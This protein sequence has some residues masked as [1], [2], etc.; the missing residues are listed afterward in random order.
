MFFL[1]SGPS[2]FCRGTRDRDFDVIAVLKTISKTLPQKIWKN[3]TGQ[4]VHYLWHV[5]PWRCDRSRPIV[6]DVT[7]VRL[8]GHASSCC[9]GRWGIH[10]N[11]IRSLAPISGGNGIRTRA[12]RRIEW[13]PATAHWWL[14]K[15]LLKE[16]HL[17]AW[18][19][20]NHWKNY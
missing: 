14:L 7:L 8:D 1:C 13:I 3:L 12:C 5:W 6:L 17:T 9:R 16:W 2:D 20:T 10:R 15:K 4:A 19:F 18:P 11:P